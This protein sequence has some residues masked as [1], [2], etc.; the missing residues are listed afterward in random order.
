MRGFGAA[1]V[2][3]SAVIDGIMASS[4]GRPTATP[5]PR[6]KVRRERCFFVMYIATPQADLKVGLY[7]LFGCRFPHLKRRALHNP[8]HDRREAIVVAGSVAHDLPHGR[9]VVVLDASTESIRHKL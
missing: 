1:A 9:H 6:R 3:A 2:C 8:H 5:A 4:S 7:R